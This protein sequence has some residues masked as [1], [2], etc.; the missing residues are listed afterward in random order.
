[1]INQYFNVYA[2]RRVRIAG[3]ATGG[4]NGFYHIELAP[5]NRVDIMNFIILLHRY[6]TIP[7]MCFVQ[8]MC[9]LFLCALLFY[10]LFYF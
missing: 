8:V 2:L 9:Y 5:S 6:L 7:V 1:M 4:Y 10:V 3:Y